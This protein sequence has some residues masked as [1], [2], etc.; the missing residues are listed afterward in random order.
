MTRESFNEIIE[1]G[2]GKYTLFGRVRADMPDEPERQNTRSALI[3][4]P[5]GLDLDHYAVSATFMTED[6]DDANRNKPFF[7]YRSARDPE[8]HGIRVEA[9]RRRDDAN[10]SQYVCDYI[11]VATAKA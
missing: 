9:N 1:H 8:R 2:Q 5:P 10:P 11:V 4:I 3:Q 7:P 6:P